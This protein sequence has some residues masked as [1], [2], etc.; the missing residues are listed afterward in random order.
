MLLFAFAAV[1][2]VCAVDVCGGVGVANCVCCYSMCGCS[3]S[4]L[5][6]M[7]ACIVDVVV[8]VFVV[9]LV[10]SVRC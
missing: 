7:F 3:F 8:C 4:E 6:L 5:L 1:V 9:V 2:C 10:V